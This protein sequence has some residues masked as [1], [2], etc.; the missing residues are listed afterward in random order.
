MESF[1]FSLLKANTNQR[2]SAH[3]Q[4]QGLGLSEPAIRDILEVLVRTDLGHE[5]SLLGA[6]INYNHFRLVQIIDERPII[7]GSRILASDY[8][9]NNGHNVFSLALFRDDVGTIEILINAGWFVHA[10]VDDFFMLME[11]YKYQINVIST[12]YSL[13]DIILK[14]S[15]FKMINRFLRELSTDLFFSPEKLNQWKSKGKVIETKARLYKIFIHF[16]KIHY[17]VFNLDDFKN[18]NSALLVEKLVRTKTFE[19]FLLEYYPKTHE[20]KYESWIKRGGIASSSQVFAL[21]YL[22][23]SS[24]ENKNALNINPLKKA[25]LDNPQIRKNPKFK[26]YSLFFE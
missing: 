1:N 25:L 15:K 7:E 2:C 17:E 11:K 8:L 5:E 14:N 22:I 12:E 6:L 13:D 21:A 26:K 3:L 19:D 24:A 20:A 18:N 23:V 16:L 10:P 9:K 4:L